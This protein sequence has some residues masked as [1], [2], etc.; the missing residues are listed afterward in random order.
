M[1]FPVGLFFQR[2]GEYLWNNDIERCIGEN[3]VSHFSK[4]V[5][6]NRHRKWLL[7]GAYSGVL[8]VVIVLV[9]AWGLSS[10]AEAEERS[11][12]SVEEYCI[13]EKVV[14]S[15]GLKNEDSIE[16]V[17]RESI[18]EYRNLLEGDG[19]ETEHI[20]EIMAE[21]EEGDYYYFSTLGLSDKILYAQVYDVYYEMKGMT[22]ISTPDENKLSQIVSLVQGD[23]PEIF[24]LSGYYKSKDS[25]GMCTFSGMYTYE[26]N[27]VDSKRLF[28]DVVAENI[29]SDIPEG[30]S[31]YDI[32]AYLYRYITQ[33]TSYDLSS[34][35]NQDIS[36]VLKNGKSVCAGYAKT[37][38]FLLQKCGIQTMY[39][40]G[41]STGPHAWLIVRIDGKYYQVDVT[42]GDFENNAFIDTD[43]SFLCLPTSVIRKTHTPA[44]VWPVP[45]CNS[46]DAN[47]YVQ[48]G[49]YV[50]SIDETD[51]RNMFN[52]SMN[53][54][55]G[56]VYL[57][58]S[59]EKTYKELMN[60]LFTESKVYDFYFGE[61]T[62]YR[63]ITY[64]TNE[65][66]F[67]ITVFE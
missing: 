18:E 23:H 8:T 7:M 25:T 5:R 63:S 45:N 36:S 31:E 28:N 21:M 56:V 67:T 9:A 22:R 35:D 48:E 12:E 58:A 39:V 53:E 27:E 46:M 32:V 64:M 59:N 1:I 55:G 26:K 13:P 16:P 34:E 6:R 65:D 15:E 60:Y 42:W 61:N 49:Y 66:Y 14:L 44:E 41:E 52:K 54:Y 33:N 17:I 3:Q 47:F 19:D 43:F 51:I 37:L 30:S 29:I 62:P 4:W 11:S 40:D 38:Q 10:K 20:S 24:Y 2:S 50:T 57:M